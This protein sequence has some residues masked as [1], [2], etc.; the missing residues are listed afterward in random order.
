MSESIL[1]NGKSGS[2]RDRVIIRTSVIGI[3]AN[4]FLAAFKAAVGILS[5]SIAVILD[6]VNNLSDAL[7]SVITIAGT[8]LAGRL[9]DKK[10]PLGHGRIEYLSAMIVAGIVLYAGITSAWESLK[11][12][13]HPETPDYSIV[14]LVIIA[15]AVLV[16]ILLGRYVR[17]K[18]EEVNSGSLVASGSDAMFDAILSA[19]VFLSAVIFMASGISLEAYVGAVISVFIIRSGVE[20]MRETL[21]DILGSRADR[22]TTD[23]IK[24]LLTEE[25]IVHG[26][27]DLIMYNYGPDRNYASVHIELP[28]VM[29]VREVDR[30]TRRLEAKVYKETGVILVGV[31][32]Y[33]YNT[34]S[35]EAAR[36]QNDVRERVLVHDWALQLHGFYVDTQAK[37]MTFDVVMSFDIVP[38]E[39]LEILY[40]ELGKAYPDYR[41]SIVPDVDVSTS[42]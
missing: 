23:R 1:G 11:K 27:Y 12:I 39:G 31:G 30:L 40:E 37:E 4:V 3:L 9:P 29:T 15:A 26:A 35:D 10:H 18:G 42:D 32:L 13:I 7:S 24:K 20:M 33:S 34:G 5:N 25:E 19:S 6:A 14:S 41:I 8:K 38:A 36:L 2:D 22:E 17:A 16:K 21:D 28:D